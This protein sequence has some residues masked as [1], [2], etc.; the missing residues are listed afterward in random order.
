[1]QHVQRM[2]RISTPRTRAESD[3]AECSDAS[4]PPPFFFI[5]LPPNG[6]EKGEKARAL[7]ARPFFFFFFFF[8]ESR[9]TNARARRETKKQR[10]SPLQTKKKGVW[11]RK[12]FSWLIS[13]FQLSEDQC[14]FGGLSHGLTWPAASTPPAC[15]SSHKICFSCTASVLSVFFFFFLILKA[16]LFIQFCSKMCLPE[17]GELGFLH[18]RT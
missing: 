4:L 12:E 1:M 11:K 13:D 5:P 8:G 6:T 7:N 9:Q 17:S 10:G 16:Y 3:F 15:A 2:R 18:A 14:Q